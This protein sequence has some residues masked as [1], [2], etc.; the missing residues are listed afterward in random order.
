[1][2]KLA[3][4]A[5]LSVT[6]LYNLFGVR[7]DI[8]IALVHDAIDRVDQILEREA[9][10]E[11]PIERCRAVI[12]VSIRYFAEHEAIFRP[13]ILALYQGLSP[14]LTDKAG[15]PERAARMQH[16]A[17]EAAMSQGL[18][19]DALDLGVLSSQIY[20]GYEM[21]CC[22]WAFGQIDEAGF[23]ARALYGLY[24]ALL[25]V[26]TE[27]LRPQLEAHLHRLERELGK[28]RRSVRRRPKQSA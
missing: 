11:D 13:M 21:A 2:R 12:T 1:M 5:G 22:Q 18:I 19:R 25:A 6:T 17:L 15:T 26:A 8:L 4:E 16:V 9:P 14:D 23:R 3:Q 7:E 10:L 24:V 27:K 28:Q 20:H